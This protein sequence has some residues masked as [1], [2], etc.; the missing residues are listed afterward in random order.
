MVGVVVVVV[1]MMQVSLQP[2]N[3]ELVCLKILKLNSIVYVY[4]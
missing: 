2:W 1:F 4:A 3:K